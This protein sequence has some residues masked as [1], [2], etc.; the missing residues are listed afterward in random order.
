MLIRTSMTREQCHGVFW[1]TSVGQTNSWN[2]LSGYLSGSISAPYT[3]R[4]P[5]IAIV[6]LSVLDEKFP[7]RN[8]V[9]V[10]FTPA[11]YLKK[12][13]QHFRGR[14]DLLLQWTHNG[15][16]RDVM[17]RTLS[18]VTNVIPVELRFIEWQTT[19]AEMYA[20]VY[21]VSRT[22]FAVCALSLSGFL[23]SF[24]PLLHV[25]P[26]APC[27]RVSRFPHDNIPGLN[28][29]ALGVGL[30]RSCTFATTVVLQIVVSIS[31][32]TWRNLPFPPSF[33][34]ERDNSGGFPHTRRVQMFSD[35]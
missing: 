22:L 17:Y 28:W 21:R 32:V 27:V 12:S 26:R 23:P 35:K 18:D 15:G 9:L 2:S 5:L 30:C 1:K 29:I 8:S 14:L 6:V 13:S 34:A 20:T 24:S 25:S 11:L 31:S 33:S 3:F 19:R 4:F 7:A 10:Y 16:G